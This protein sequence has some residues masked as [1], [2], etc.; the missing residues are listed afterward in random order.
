M[1][2]AGTSWISE[3]RALQILCRE[4]DFT[5]NQAAI[6]LMHARRETGPLFDSIYIYKR[7]RENRAKEN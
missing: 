6:V 1:A 2:N 7:A 3:N 4:G 5:E